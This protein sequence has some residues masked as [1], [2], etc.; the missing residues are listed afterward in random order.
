MGK[1]D[2]YET[3]YYQ[4]PEALS[5]S[6]VQATGRGAGKSLGL[7]M[8]FS[9]KMVSMF[10][11]E[12]LLTAFRSLHVQDR[13]ESIIAFFQRISY[14]KHFLA[15][16]YPISRQPSYTLQLK[17]GVMAFGI[18]VGDD[19]SAVNMT[20]KHAKVRAIEEAQFFPS[21][22][23][24]QFQGTEH[25]EGSVD[26]YIGV[27]DGD[28]SS[29]L[30]KMDKDTHSNSIHTSS[31][32]DPYLTEHK[33]GT[34][35]KAYGGPDSSEA[36][37]QIEGLWGEPVSSGWDLTAI[38][39]NMIMEKNH[40]DYIAYVV[41]ITKTEFLAANEEPDLF[42][43]NLP[44]K[45][46]LVHY[47]LGIDVGDG[48]PTVIL[49]Y[50][51]YGGTY[52][53]LA[54]IH[55][56]E[57]MPPSTQQ[58]KVVDYIYQK[59]SIEKPTFMAIDCSSGDGRSLCDSLQGVYNIPAENI[60]RVMFQ[61]SVVTMIDE[62][63]TEKKENTKDFTVRLL[64][65]LFTERT[66]DKPIMLLPYDSNI[67]EAFGRE[68]KVWEARSGRYFLRTPV[69]VHIPEA[70]RCFCMLVWK[71]YVMFDEVQAPTHEWIV[72]S[73]GNTPSILRSVQ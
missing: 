16:K 33:L 34:R 47:F 29:V 52:Q 1:E 19:P 13:M 45:N 12:M 66:D 56:K 28:V 32:F 37:N 21:Y 70:M 41:E 11:C 65:R 68:K 31:R 63:G 55:L 51:D 14:F 38:K 30:Y 35:Q 62:K 54:R 61:E 48:Q 53:L 60:V 46:E 6:A 59:Y 50:A 42:L 3:R 7:E 24:V 69:D 64:R 71:F 8:W 22:A 43:Y 67:L 5:D 17:T 27:P 49:I 73:W 26:R 44:T 40:P 4:Y 36:K 9:H 2:F 10:N 20:G 39:Q 72:P 18:S 23:F 57:K 58:A 15:D 25:P